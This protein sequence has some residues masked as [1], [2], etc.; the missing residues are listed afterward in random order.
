MSRENIQQLMQ[1]FERAKVSDEGEDCW[2]ARSLSAL[3]GYKDWDNFQRV[4]R[5]ARESCINAG[6][7]PDIHFREATEIVMAGIASRRIV[8]YRLTRWGA[9]LAAMNGDV[10]KERIS[11]AQVYF[12]ARTQQAEIIEQKMLLHDRVAARRE[13]AMS[14]AD[15]SQ[16]MHEIG[17]TGDQMGRVRSKGDR[18][19]FGGKSTEDMKRQYGMVDK[20]GNVK[21][22]PL[23]NV[24][25]TVVQRGKA[26]AAELT[27]Q[28]IK[29][30]A[31]GELRIA[32][33]HEDHN[34]D[35]RGVMSKAGIIP[36][37]LPPDVDTRVLERQ[38]KKE[39]EEALRAAGARRQLSMKP[40]TT[41]PGVTGKENASGFDPGQQMSLPLDE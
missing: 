1:E 31:R 15:F 40:P 5:K 23:G 11:F 22:D 10:K 26:F 12:V 25:P 7:D 27:K 18:A 19:L 29:G 32:R 16:A 28:K 4:I 13:L 33:H 6:G 2:S 21:K 30:G 38:M 8:D 17:L 34:M 20:K 36:E 41:S 39:E 14:E 24:L 37:D 35:V 9:Y 3:L